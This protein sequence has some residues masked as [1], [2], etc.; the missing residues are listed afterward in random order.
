[1]IYFGSRSHSDIVSFPS[2]PVDPMANCAAVKS[3]RNRSV[4][5]GWKNGLSRGRGMA[6][7]LWCLWEV[8]HEFGPP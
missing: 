1:M 3:S 6:S 5:S 7:G 4:E 2:V 8:F